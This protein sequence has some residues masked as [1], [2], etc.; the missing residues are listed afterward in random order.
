MIYFCLLS[1]SI[2][3]LDKRRGRKKER[4]QMQNKSSFFRIFGRMMRIEIGESQISRPF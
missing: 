3:L 4:R 1:L 2:T